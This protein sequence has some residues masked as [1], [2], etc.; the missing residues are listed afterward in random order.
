MELCVLCALCVK[1]ECCVVVMSADYMKMFGV[2][3]SISTVA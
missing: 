3:P 2:Y 1:K